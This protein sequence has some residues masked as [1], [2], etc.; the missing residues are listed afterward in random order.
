M[1]C[2]RPRDR[3]DRDQASMLSYIPGNDGRWF[4]EANYRWHNYGG[5]DIIVTIPTTASAY[6][7]AG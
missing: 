4:A 3:G 5:G 7:D 2:C 6:N 1:V